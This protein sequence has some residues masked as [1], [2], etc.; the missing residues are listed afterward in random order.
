MPKFDL[1]ETDVSDLAAFLHSTIQSVSNRGDYKILDIVVGDAKAGAAFFSGAG[2]CSTCHSTTGDLKG[3]G[4]LYD[5]TTLQGRFVMPRGGPRRRPGGGRDLPP[6]LEKAAVQATVKTAAG[7][8]F[9]GPLILVTDFDVMVYD[10]AT[11]QPRTWLRTDGIPT[12]TLTDPLQA[13]VDMLRQWKD[14]D[15]HN[16]TAFLAS[17]K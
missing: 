4:A 13:H 5:P 14:K 10:A 9:T 7:E 8:T 17:L 15:I 1:P 11:Q 16:M 12:V 3:I 2:K 6:F